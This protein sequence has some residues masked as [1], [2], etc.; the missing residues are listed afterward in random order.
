MG[1]PFYSVSNCQADPALLLFQLH[2][3]VP[4]M[5]LV[6]ILIPSIAHVI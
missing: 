2:W 4:Q 6:L 5:Q 1:Y 3:V